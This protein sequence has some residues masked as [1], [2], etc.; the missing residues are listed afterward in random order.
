MQTRIQKSIFVAAIAALFVAP[1][2]VHAAG[3]GGRVVSPLAAPA[4]GDQTPTRLMSVER[5]HVAID[6]APVSIS[7]ALP[8]SGK[9]DANPRPFRKLSRQYLVN[10]TGAQLQ[11]GVNLPITAVDDIVRISPLG[12]SAAVDASS[13]RFVSGGRQLSAAAASD[14]IASGR[15]MRRAGMPVQTGS[16]VLKLNDK[17]GAGTARIAAAGARGRYLIQV[18][19]PK[20]PYALAL[21][22]N[23]G[24]TLAGD[25]LRF[26]VDMAGS[27]AG[28][29]HSRG[30]RAR[31]TRVTGMLVAPDG[32]SENVRFTRAANGSYIASV[33]P[34]AAHA[35]KRGLWE[36]RAFARARSGGKLVLREATNAFAVTLPTARFSGSLV[37]FAPR[38]G[39]NLRV[40]VDVDVAAAS[41]YAVS[42]VL[43]GHDAKGNL[44]PAVYAQSAAWLQPG[45]DVPIRLAFQAAAITRSGLTGPFQLRNLKLEDQLQLGVLERR[46]IAARGLVASP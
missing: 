30:V 4:A 46:A 9:I 34:P 1:L 23:R 40:D 42:A 36:I 13:V 26:K 25:T 27:A 22:A 19:E 33:M 43:Y 17:V 11:R 32:W 3:P 41:R 20:S 14:V 18:Y 12:A 29:A 37:R 10:A 21:A 15:Q 2:A 8:A 38:A 39:Q 35:G 45:H 5:V 24:T 6:H 44:R 16:T 7:W 31:L 28:V